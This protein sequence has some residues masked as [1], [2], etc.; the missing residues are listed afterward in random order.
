M[1]GEQCLH[2]IPVHFLRSSAP[3]FK[4]FKNFNLRVRRDFMSLTFISVKTLFARCILMTVEF[5]DK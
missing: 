3:H 5:G 1:V 4:A 2:S